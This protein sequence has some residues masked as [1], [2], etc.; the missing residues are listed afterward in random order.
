MAGVGPPLGPPLPPA[1]SVASSVG[2]S[3]AAVRL[4]SAPISGSSVVEGPRLP[5]GFSAGAVVGSVE[6]SSVVGSG[7]FSVGL[8][9]MEI[10]GN[11][12]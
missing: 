7:R 4:P 6:G 8:I 12:A 1:S 3:G 11:E 10:F 2:A 9:S 5:L